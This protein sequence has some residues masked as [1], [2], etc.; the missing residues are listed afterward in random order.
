MSDVKITVKGN[1][2]YRIEGEITL[3]AGTHNKVGFSSAP[4]AVSL[5]AAKP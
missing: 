3:C 5:P 1:G 4:E 2:P